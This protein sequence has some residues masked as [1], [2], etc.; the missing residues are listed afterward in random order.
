MLTKAYSAHSPLASVVYLPE[1]GEIVCFGSNEKALSINSV[2]IPE[3][4]TR[5]S[6][7]VKV[8]NP[9]KRAKMLYVKL[10]SE[11]GISDN[12]P[13]RSRNIPSAGTK[14]SAK[15]KDGEQLSLLD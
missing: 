2:V 7:G 11:S 15:D 8:F 9:G 12:K 1:D 10:L 13:Y 14:L 5:N 6:H 4:A 3:K